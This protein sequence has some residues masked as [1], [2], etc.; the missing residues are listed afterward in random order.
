ML[1]MIAHLSTY[2]GLI[3]PF[4]NIVA[5]FGVWLGQRKA[6][7]YIRQHAAEA[8]N[9]QASITVYLL[10]AGIIFR[11]SIYQALSSL[12]TL[13]VVIVVLLAAYAALQGREYRY[14]LALRILR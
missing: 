11:E 13:F 3:L 4:G 12:A 9:F 2:L 8:F 7:P 6:S 10:A 1:A 5:P 14:P